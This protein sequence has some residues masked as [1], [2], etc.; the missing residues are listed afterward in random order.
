MFTFATFA[1]IFKKKER[2]PIDF[3]YKKIKSKKYLKNTSCGP[4]V[5]P[6]R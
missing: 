5:W 4:S 3:F 2:S 6:Y 1:C